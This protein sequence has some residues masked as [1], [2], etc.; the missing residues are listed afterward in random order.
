MR[1][2][3]LDDQPI[4]NK[5]LNKPRPIN[6]ERFYLFRF[7]HNGLRVPARGGRGLGP[8]TVAGWEAWDHFRRRIHTCCRTT[9]NLHR[10]N[11]LLR[12]CDCPV[13]GCNFTC[14]GNQI[15]NMHLDAHFRRQMS[16]SIDL[17][18]CSIM[19]KGNSLP[20]HKRPNY[21]AMKSPV[22]HDNPTATQDEIDDIT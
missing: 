19:D 20:I 8:P 10:S 17:R 18:Q 12:S 22:E 15:M 13:P 7:T 5:T 21:F 1:K 11:P 2:P 3:R 16:S 6:C 4:D 9:K 14:D